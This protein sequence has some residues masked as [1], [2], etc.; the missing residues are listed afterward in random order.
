MNNNN[1]KKNQHYVWRKYLE[2]WADNGKIFCLRNNNIF[3]TNTKNIGVENYF[4]KLPSLNGDEIRL[5]QDFIK[6]LNMSDKIKN[7]NYGWLENLFIPF[8]II[9]SL[10]I[11]DKETVDKLNKMEINCEED[12]HSRIESDSMSFIKSILKGNIDV[13]YSEE[14]YYLSFIYFICTQYFRT[15]KMKQLISNFK[16]INKNINT[17]NIW[18]VLRFILTTNLSYNLITL[19][20]KII[21]IRNESSLEF[22]A[23][24]Q[25][26]INIYPITDENN[27]PKK[28]IFYYPISPKIA[29][30]IMENTESL[31]KSISVNDC[32]KINRW[33]MLIVEK[34]CEQIYACS[35][36]TLKLYKT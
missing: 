12:Y 34:S 33:N 17:E 2:S 24:D 32:K 6:S 22:I 26:L 13:L 1:N 10:N 16:C 9:K 15:K 28:L 18:P 11:N 31:K 4:Y 3:Q 30:L 5:I 36:K 7:L 21:L 23:G 35:E 29:L 27:S 14:N 25:P 8:A 20:Y 19:K